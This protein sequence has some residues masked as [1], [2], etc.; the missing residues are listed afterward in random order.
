M[1]GRINPSIREAHVVGGGFS[2]M[3]AAYR[4]MRAGYQ[5]TLYESTQR[6]G[7]LLASQRTPFGLSEV[8]AHSMLASPAVERFFEEL[9]LELLTVKNRSRFILRNGK[10]RKFPLTFFEA[11]IAAVRAYFVLSKPG[12]QT[13]EE[14]GLRHLGRPAVRY[15]LTPFVRGVFGVEPSALS[16]QAAF[17]VLVVPPGHSLLSWFLRKLFRSERKSPRS[18]HKRMVAPRDGME[19]I[20]RAM[21]RE[22]VAQLG[23]RVKRGHIFQMNAAL[24]NL[25]LAVPTPELAG[26]LR[27]VAPEAASK[28]DD[29]RYTSLVSVTAFVSRSE[30]KK[31][32][33]GVGVLFPEDEGMK[34]LGILFNSSSFDHRVA[35]ESLNSYTIILKSGLDDDGIRE[36]VRSDLEKVFGIQK[37]KASVIHRWERA[38]PIYDQ[39][40]E[41]AWKSLESSWCQTPGRIVFGNHS[42]DVSLRGMIERSEQLL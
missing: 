28:L 35:D 6:L 24:P 23:D 21:E 17:P 13:L 34:S 29:V 7:G 32:C 31:P 12:A 9:H 42:G 4:L 38:I 5:V 20:V 16:V 19:S 39:T 41:Q 14:W 40:L 22:L 27:Q 37:V 1:I 11:V 8:A 30:I 10:L 26:M 18:R 2:G 25:V 15:L 36:A 3:L 33:E